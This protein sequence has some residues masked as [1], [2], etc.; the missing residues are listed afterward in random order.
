MMKRLL[1]FI[2]MPLR[3]KLMLPEAFLLSAYYRWQIDH[4]KFADISPRIGTLWLET[5]FEQTPAAAKQIKGIVEAVC[6]RTPW[7]CT[8]LIRALTAKKLLNR[9]GYPCTLYMGVKA[10]S[11]KAME[12]HAWLRCGR[13][14]V[15]GGSGA[16]YTVTTIYGDS[17]IPHGNT[18]NG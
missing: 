6:K 4:R 17:C 8:C 5:P 15:T 7:E 13:L 3:S 11:G 18:T 9:R 14:F 10:K 2:R 12:A 16:G 1:K